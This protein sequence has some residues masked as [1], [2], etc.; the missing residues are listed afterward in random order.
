MSMFDELKDKAADALKD[1]PDKVEQVSDGLLEKAAGL[2][3]G[4]TGGKFHDQIEGL[5]EK[6]D[7]AIGE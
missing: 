1:N 5:A 6:A 7:G 2:A 3:D 4:A